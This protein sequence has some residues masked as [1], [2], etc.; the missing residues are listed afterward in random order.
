MVIVLA[1]DD[2]LA[3]QKRLDEL[4]AKFVKEYG[5]LA[6]ERLD[7]EEAEAAKISEAA[8]SLPLLSARKSLII[9]SLGNNKSASENIEQIISSI[10][11]ST[12]LILHE[13]NIDKRSSYYK[14]LRRQKGFEEHSKPKSAELPAWLV[15]RAQAEGGQLGRAD[16]A[17]L[18]QKVGPEPLRLASELSKLITYQPKITRQN[19]DLLVEVTPQSRIFDLLDAAF[20]GKKD[21]ALALYEDQR[22]QR[23]EPQA[24]LAMLAWQLQALAVVKTAGERSADQIAKDS[25]LNPFTISKSRALAGKIS[26]D[27]LKKLVGQAL[28][29]DYKSKTSPIE[30]DEA[31]RNYLI[32]I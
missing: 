26:L 15:K 21:Q 24:I 16:A 9:R 25:G 17:Y 6:V 11:E 30:L 12:D 5:D 14:F 29:I 31:L 18:L 20:A 1:G 2:G 28:N 8:H 3:I 13:P 27:Q 4:L 23:V 32:S 10:P 19:I 7:G 22:R